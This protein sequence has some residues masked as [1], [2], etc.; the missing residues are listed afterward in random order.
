MG[1]ANIN[2]KLKQKIKEW[3]NKDDNS[4]IIPNE[5]SFINRACMELLRKLKREKKRYV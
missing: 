3:L 2:P 5:V 1:N 4:L